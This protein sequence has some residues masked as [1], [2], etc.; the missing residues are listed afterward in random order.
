LKQYTGVII[1]IIV[2]LLSYVIFLSSGRSDSAISRGFK[3]VYDGDYDAFR[4]YDLTDTEKS[5]LTTSETP[6][7]Y[8]TE[9]DGVVQEVLKFLSLFEHNIKNGTRYMLNVTLRS[10]FGV[11]ESAIIESNL[12]S[13]GSITIYAKDG[14]APY[15]WRSVSIISILND[16]LIYVRIT[17][18][19]YSRQFDVDQC[20][21]I[22]ID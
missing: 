7:S 10:L 5:D 18:G 4:I 17:P 19:L 8:Y 9:H 22:E 16:T 13:N 20:H 6:T 12:I 3:A 15:Y 14:V 2:I 21:I 11:T 1:I